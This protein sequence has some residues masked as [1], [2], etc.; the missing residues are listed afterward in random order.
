MQQAGGGRGFH[1]ETLL[2]VPWAS[3]LGSGIR[4]YPRKTAQ[5]PHRWR[6]GDG[7]QRHIHLPRRNPESPQHT[8]FELNS[9]GILAPRRR[10]DEAHR[11]LV[12]HDRCGH[13]TEVGWIDQR[14]IHHAW[15]ICSRWTIAGLPSSRASSLRKRWGSCLGGVGPGPC[16]WR[17]ATRAKGALGASNLA[18]RP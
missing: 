15:C 16:A 4:G 7:K 5:K 18:T 10:G 1:F 2:D 6:L 9:G 11:P 14:H 17:P 8:S 13:D 12:T 3:G